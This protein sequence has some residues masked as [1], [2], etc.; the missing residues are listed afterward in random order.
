MR[1]M[2][3]PVICAL[4][5]AACGGDGD[6]GA[7]ASTTPPTPAA[8]ST[9]SGAVVPFG[10]EP[11]DLLTP[12][13]VA[14]ATGSAVVAVA[15]DPPVSCVYDLDGIT[16]DLFVAV[17]DAQGRMAGA[18]FLFAGYRDGVEAGEAEVIDGLGSAAV[19]SPGFR[20]LAVDAGG[21]RFFAVGVSGG[22]DG[23][24]DPRPVLTDLAAT[25]LGRL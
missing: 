23:L 6:D 11:C 2:F 16:A 18:A 8:S 9:T 3:V 13:E 17:D 1:R 22:Y 21:G 25:V 4:L 24:D 15:E 5:L 20:T 19:F 12:G 10:V 14:D 7:G